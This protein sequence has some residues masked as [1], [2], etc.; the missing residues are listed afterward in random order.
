M[1]YFPLSLHPSQKIITSLFREWGLGGIYFS[2]DFFM[3]K[4]IWN[5]IILRKTLMEMLFGNWKLWTFF[6]GA[7]VLEIIQLQPLFYEIINRVYF[8]ETSH[9]FRNMHQKVYSPVTAVSSES[10]FLSPS[11]SFKMISNITIP[12]LSLVMCSTPS[13]QARHSTWTS[14]PTGLLK[15]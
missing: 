7:S 9:M 10:A 6:A 5:T 3:F 12:V 1:K 8:I 11:I 15:I 14:W 13:Y 2:Y 4:A